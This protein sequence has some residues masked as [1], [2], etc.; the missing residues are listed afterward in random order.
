M[1]NLT[2]QK[3]ILSSFELGSI[4]KVK[5]TNKLKTK[6]VYGLYLWNEDLKLWNLYKEYPTKQEAMIIKNRF[7]TVY[8]A[9]MKIEKIKVYA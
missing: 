9:N 6:T 4:K 7:F 5:Q 3:K 2:Q 1:E 8:G